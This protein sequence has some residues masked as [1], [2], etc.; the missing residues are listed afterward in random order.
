MSAPSTGLGAFTQRRGTQSETGGA[1]FKFL[2]FVDQ[3][4]ELRLVTCSFF[5]C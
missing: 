1:G 4:H 3:L 2:L 5:I